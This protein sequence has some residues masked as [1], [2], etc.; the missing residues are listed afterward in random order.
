MTF[1]LFF[2]ALAYKLIKTDSVCDERM[3]I[4]ELR[5]DLEDNQML[6]CLRAVHPPHGY[7]ETNEEKNRRIAAQWDT[8]CSFEADYDWRKPL[9]EIHEIANLVDSVGDIVEKDFDD[10]AD[11]CE[12]VRAAIAAG[13]LKKITSDLIN[14]PMKVLDYIDCVGEPEQS[15]ICA[16]TGSSFFQNDTWYIMLDGM[17]VNVDGKPRFII[18][19]PEAQMPE[20]PEVQKISPAS[21]R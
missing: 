1:L 18:T 13:K 21:N 8:A 16:V 3:L 19:P 7:E 10:Q 9:R 5:Q 14:I 4:L 12:I 17:T 11:M 20:I 15:E 2:L 6:D